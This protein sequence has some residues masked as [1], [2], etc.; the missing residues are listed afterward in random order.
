MFLFLIYRYIST[1]LFIYIRCD[2]INFYIYLHEFQ[3]HVIYTLPYLLTLA[4]FNL[5]RTLLYMMLPRTTT[6]LKKDSPVSSFGLL[7][8]CEKEFNKKKKYQQVSIVYTDLNLFLFLIMK[9][10]KYI[11]IPLSLKTKEE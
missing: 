6:F 2:L 7:D 8:F 11:N 4:E 3:L 1:N 10:I 5:D 9:K